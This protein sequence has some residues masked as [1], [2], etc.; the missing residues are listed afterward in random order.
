M[1]IELKLTTDEITQAWPVQPLCV[2]PGASIR[3]VLRQMKERRSGSVLICRG[4]VLAGIFTER[5]ALRLLAERSNLDRPIEEVM[6]R[7]PVS[8]KADATVATAVLRMS[9]GGYRRL[10]LVD[11]DGRPIGL[12]EVAGIM[13]YL[14]EH[15]PKTVYNLP[16]TPHPVTHER[17]GP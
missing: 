10:P 17:E 6:V 5:D 7:N 14:V 4:G 15:F 16:P 11:A 2:E 13:H 12:I 3:D 1:D 8:L 9:S